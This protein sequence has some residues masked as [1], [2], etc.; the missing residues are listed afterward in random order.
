[1][2]WRIVSSDET[3]LLADLNRQ[4]QE[5]EGSNV[6]SDSALRLRLAKWL[7]SGYRAVAFEDGGRL[8]AYALFRDTDP[9][10]EGAKGIYLRQFFVVDTERR[11]GVG[12]KA[13]AILIDEVWPGNRRIILEALSENAAGRAFWIS[14]GFR[15]YSVKYEYERPIG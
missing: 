3:E 4:L 11:R 8:V 6:M 12:R 2:R 7:S 5:H 14:L 1:M 10:S 9:D 13:F 15:E